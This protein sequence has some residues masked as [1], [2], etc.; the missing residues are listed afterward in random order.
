[1]LRGGFKPCVQRLGSMA[2]SLRACGTLCFLKTLRTAETLMST[3]LETLQAEVLRLLPQDRARLLDRL[4]ASLD[5]DT[6]AQAAWD[7]WQTSDKERSSPAPSSP[8][9]S[10]LL[11]RSWKRASPDEGHASS[12]S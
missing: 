9:P 7:P 12:W 1:M 2:V 8:C 3:T 5:V 10:T 11:L 6:E 4:I